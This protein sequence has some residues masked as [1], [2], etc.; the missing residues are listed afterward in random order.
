MPFYCP[1]SRKKALGCLQIILRQG[2]FGHYDPVRRASADSGF[3]Q[4]KARNGMKVVH[5]QSELFRLLP[6]EVLSYLPW[7]LA[8]GVR[9][10]FT[11]K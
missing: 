6:R 3:L 7:Y 11:G 10:I 4:R 5:Q 1:E 9:R 8:D 2:N